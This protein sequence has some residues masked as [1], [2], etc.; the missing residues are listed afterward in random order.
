MPRFHFPVHNEVFP[1][2]DEE[3]RE[4]VDFDAATHEAR[5][6]ACEILM[7]EL[8]DREQVEFTIY[9][10]NGDRKRLFAVRVSASSEGLE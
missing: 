9:V 3:G 7:T 6:A 4:L 8:I 5:R 10:E 1:S 2:A